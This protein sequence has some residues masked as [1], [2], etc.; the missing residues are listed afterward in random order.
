MVDCLDCFKKVIKG[1]IY[2][3]ISIIIRW[4]NKTGAFWSSKDLRY[5]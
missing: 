4:V 3:E 5:K 1:E 2:P